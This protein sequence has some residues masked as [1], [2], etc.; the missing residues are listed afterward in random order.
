MIR[1]R[2]YTLEYFLL[3]CSAVNHKVWRYF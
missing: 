3:W 2:Y 1:E